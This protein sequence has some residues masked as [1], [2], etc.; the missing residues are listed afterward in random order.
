[1]ATLI[2]IGR[3]RA[4][5]RRLAAA[6]RLSLAAVMAATTIFG[7]VGTVAAASQSKDIAQSFSGGAAANLS[8]EGFAPCDECVPD[9]LFPNTPGAIALGISVKAEI[10]H[11]DYS[12]DATTSVAYNDSEL[13]Q[14]AT[15]HTTDVF[16]PSN[17]KVELKGNISGDAGFYNSPNF[18]PLG[19][20]FGFET[21]EPISIPFDETLDCQLTLTGD[22]T[23]TCDV[24]LASLPVLSLPV[25][26]PLFVDL[27]FDFRVGV[28]VDG[29]G[30]ATVRAID[31]VGGD[32]LATDPLTFDGSSPSVTMADSVD[33]PCTAPVGSDLSY[34]LTDS[35][36]A[37]GVSLNSKLTLIVDASVELVPGAP[38]LTLWDK[39]LKDFS[40]TNT[41]LDITLTA[42][43]KA[44]DLGPIAK[45]NI[46]PVADPGPSLYSGTQGSP[47]TFS[48]LGSTSVCGFPT[49]RWDFSDGGVAYGALPQHT[50]GGAGLYSG[51]LTATDL[52]GLTSTATFAISVAN[53]APVANAGPDTT[54]AWGRPVQFNGSA[55]DPGADDQATLAYAWAF[56]DGLSFAGGASTIH[57]YAN[58][59]VYDATFTATDQHGASD[60]DSRTV[61]VRKRTVTAAFLGFDGTYDTTG[62]LSSTLVDE[63]GSPVVGRTVS[64]AVDGTPVGSVQTNGSGIATLGYTPTV[65][66]GS[67]GVEVSFSAD[68]LYTG[69]AANG[70][71]DVALK[72]TSLAYTGALKGSPNKA[73]SLSAVLKD[74]TGQALAGRTVSFKLGSQS[75]SATTDATGVATVSLVLNQKN[76]SYPLTATFTPAGADA[77]RYL[78]SSASVTFSLQKK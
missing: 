19:P 32:N 45:N 68:A 4:G 63:F 65:A 58:P 54:A 78:A 70:S 7:A 39:D 25:L 57:S 8:M 33:I 37:P 67:H 14:G 43:D 30:V 35:S 13:R 69:A 38:H 1:M 29:A 74:A 77:S 44:T 2:G 15:L 51:L 60:D 24:T 5:R 64:F 16:M 55:T 59:G 40:I 47:I 56:G 72:A 6:S 75:A 21:I 9:W 53:A 31:V 71:I 17:G 49:L 41:P 66:A 61:T 62:N 22:G 18:D 20:W 52:T 34:G 11:V 42:A 76:G 3:P 10:T 48:G 46:A 12:S 27:S 73:V 26:Y 28:D 50:F 23:R 36:Y